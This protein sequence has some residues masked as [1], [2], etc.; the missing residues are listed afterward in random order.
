MVLPMAL[1]L[2]SANLFSNVLPNIMPCIGHVQTNNAV[3]WHNTTYGH[4]AVIGWVTNDAMPNLASHKTGPLFIGVLQPH[5]HYVSGISLSF[6]ATQMKPSLVVVFKEHYRIS[7]KIYA[8]L[9]LHLPLYMETL[10]CQISLSRKKMRTKRAHRLHRLRLLQMLTIM[11]QN[12]VN[13]WCVPTQILRLWAVRA[14]RR[15]M[16]CVM[17]P[18]CRF[19]LL[20][21]AKTFM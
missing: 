18:Q 9:H 13:Q 3:C 12:R 6:Q 7:S 10:K 2:T 14:V 15:M 8:M 17:L 4:K 11:R 19:S 16:I 5:H 20:K 1:H 21:I